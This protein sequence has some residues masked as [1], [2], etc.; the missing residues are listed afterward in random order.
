MGDGG[1]SDTYME[2]RGQYS[3]SLH[4]SPSL[5]LRLSLSLN[6]YLIDFVILAGQRAPG[7]LLSLPPLGWDYKCALLVWEDLLHQP[8]SAY[9][10]PF[11]T[12]MGGY[13]GSE[14]RSS[15]WQGRPFT[16]QAI[17]RPSPS[18]HIAKRWVRM[19][20]GTRIMS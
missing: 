13:W 2:A 8:A 15:C 3:M 5:V 10:L 11:L 19:P 18:S 6:L 16:D 12:N 14:L 20:G 17:Y 1:S 4:H 7:I 9:T